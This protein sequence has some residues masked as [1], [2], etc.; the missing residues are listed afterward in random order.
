MSHNN[1]T[2]NNNNTYTVEI[3]TDPSSAGG[4]G[5]TTS[6]DADG[7]V[8]Y[9]MD[10]F[11]TAFGTPLFAGNFTIDGISPTY[12]WSWN[13]NPIG[14]TNQSAPT[15][16]HSYY[17]TQLIQKTLIGQYGPTYTLDNNPIYGPIKFDNSAYISGGF[18]T[19]GKR[20]TW[21]KIILKEVYQDI[22]GLLEYTANG[23]NESASSSEFTWIL[24]GLPN[25]NLF[26]SNT[27]VPYK[28]VAYVYMEYNFSVPLADET[29]NIDF[30]QIP[31]TGGCTDPFADNFTPQVHFDDGSCTY[32]G[33]LHGVELQIDISDAP[34]ITDNYTDGSNYSMTIFN[35]ITNYTTINFDQ[36]TYVN[37]NISLSNTSNLATSV[38]VSPNTYT[39]GTL[40]QES[41]EFYIYPSIYTVVNTPLPNMYD[42]PQVSGSIGNIV[43]IPGYEQRMFYGWGN[44]KNNLTAASLRIQNP[45][46]LNWHEP[47][48][49]DS[50]IP[51]YTPNMSQWHHQE[52]ITG[53][54]PTEIVNFNNFTN[55]SST[56]DT[57]SLI[58]MQEE[59]NTLGS[60]VYDWFPEKVKVTITLD[61]VM[62]NGLGNNVA[63]VVPVKIYHD[64]ENQG[65]LNWVA[66]I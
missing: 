9:K 8:Y 46:T 3:A 36:T 54:Q 29:L 16:P 61:F 27:E 50:T 18:T 66:P 53:L 51:G 65:D 59:Y 37:G 33:N 2:L 41:H 43:N 17:T 15:P 32:S 12:K 13:A 31:P 22:N 40:V 19:S 6:Y 4:P 11:P 1:Y 28:I 21:S 60:G 20:A 47:I 56:V 63:Y 58:Q 30:D 44:A 5:T 14:P 45:G 35:V 39:A 48:Y 55:T 57:T 7:N 23:Q 62:P 64:T 26:N 34:A 49:L 25:L 52:D 38:V 10:I 24:S 42:F